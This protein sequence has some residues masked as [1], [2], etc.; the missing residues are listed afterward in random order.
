[1]TKY[2]VGKV[3]TCNVTGI[4]K[5]GIFVSL[6]NY[7]SGL[8]HISEISYNFVNNINDYVKI[9]DTIKAKVISVDEDTNHIKLSIKDFEKIKARKRTPI[10]E[11]GTGFEI[12]KDHLDDWIGEKN[13]EYEKKKKKQKTC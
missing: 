13:K 1:M 2:K 4:E 3:I 7:Y 5:Y 10:S 11:V 9:G 12:L 6:D 8:I